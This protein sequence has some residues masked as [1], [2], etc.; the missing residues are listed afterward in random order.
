MLSIWGGFGEGFWE[1]FGRVWEPFG[2][3][4]RLSGPFFAFFAGVDC[5]LLVLDALG[6]LGGVWG[7]FL[8]G[9]AGLGMTI[10]EEVLL[11]A[12][13]IAEASEASEQSERAKLFGAARAGAH[14]NFWMSEF[15][16]WTCIKEY[17]LSGALALH[18]QKYLKKIALPV[19]C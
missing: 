1:G 17:A 5:F 13:P 18:V 7:G 10:R 8:L 19:P 4:W 16:A 2:H 15:H 11:G 12:G 14:M 9:F 6:G 3:S